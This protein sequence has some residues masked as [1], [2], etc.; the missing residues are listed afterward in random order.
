MRYSSEGGSLRLLYH[1]VRREL[2]PDGAQIAAM[3]DDAFLLLS[4]PLSD[5]C[6]HLEKIPR[7]RGDRLGRGDVQHLRF[8]PIPGR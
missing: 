7:I 3:D 6:D 2:Y 4:E 8:A 1:H 5:A